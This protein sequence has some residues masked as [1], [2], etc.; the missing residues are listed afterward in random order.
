VDGAE[1]PTALGHRRTASN[2][3]TEEIVAMGREIE[4]RQGIGWYLKKRGK[5]R[6]KD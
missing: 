5:D 2:E 1:L 3:N 4:S 6:T